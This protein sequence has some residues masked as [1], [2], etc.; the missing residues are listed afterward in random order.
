MFE[1]LSALNVKGFKARQFEKE[2]EKL[3][4]AQCTFKPKINDYKI[5]SKTYRKKE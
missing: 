3:E 4:L 1:Y 5:R 2:K